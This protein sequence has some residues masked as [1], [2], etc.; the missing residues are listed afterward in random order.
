MFESAE[1][2][3]KVE[4]KDYAERVPALREQLL[5]EQRRLAAAPLSVVLVVGG[6]EGAGK[7]DLV[8]LVLEWTDARGVEVSALWLPT[9]EESARPPMWRVWRT[10]PPKG[11]LGAFLGS[12]Y[13]QPILDRV[14]GHA[15]QLEF[16]IA[17]DR[18]IEFE[19]MLHNENTLIV[20]LWLHIGEKTQHRRLE[21]L[22]KDP[23]QSWRVTKLDWQFFKHYKRFARVSEHAIRRTSTGEAP[24]HIIEATDWRYRNLTA[25]TVLLEALRTRLDQIAAEPPPE[26][27]PDLPTP[28]PVSVLRAL[29]LSVKLDDETADR[30]L[31]KHMGEVARL[32]RRLSEAKRSVVLVFEGPDAAGKGGAIRRLTRAIDARLYRVVPVSAPSDEESAR[33][34]LWRFWRHLPPQG[35]VTIFD[36]SWY[37]R[38]LVERVEGFCPQQDWQRAY[39]EINSFEQQLS[40]FGVIVLKFWLWISPEEQLRR[41]KDRQAT[42]YKQ[43]KLTEDDWRNRK[44]WDAYEAAACDMIE[45]TSSEGAPWVAVE[46]DDKNWARGKVLATV[47]KTLAKELD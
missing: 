32:S 39:S 33:P 24:W 42:A 8:N 34:Y 37:G 29:D 45:K 43:Y 1:V 14:L 9:D 23:R 19:R 38:V 21:K 46:A 28:K 10:L 7:G 30:R 2:G 12:W 18:A 11:R 31:L 44:K 6:V 15:K 4:K 36:R 25:A 20:K 26:L 40:D 5:G 35:R 27:V 16:D 13:T 17:L 47:A 41:F 3:N 22:E